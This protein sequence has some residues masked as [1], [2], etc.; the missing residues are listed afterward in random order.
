MRGHPM[1]AAPEHGPVSTLPKARPETAAPERISHSLHAKPK[2]LMGEVAA[3]KGQMIAAGRDAFRAFMLARR[4]TP[5]GWAA[6]AGVPPGEV[7]AFLTG[8][9]RIIPPASAARL[10]A[11]AGCAVDDMFH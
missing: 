7:M 4:L 3:P 1:T 6:A 2:V 11:V 8:R 9:A 10:A 5:R